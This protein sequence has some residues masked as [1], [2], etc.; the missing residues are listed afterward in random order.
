MKQ[1]TDSGATSPS[2]KGKHITHSERQQIERWLKQ[3][4]SQSEIARLL[5]KSRVTIYREIR[6]GRV[7]QPNSDGT[8]TL[9]YNARHAQDSYAEKFAAHG[10]G[11]K[12]ERNSE[13]AAQL[14]ELLTGEHRYS[15][16]A[17]RQ[18]LID[19]GI[20]V[21]FSS[22]TIYNYIHKQVINVDSKAQPPRKKPRH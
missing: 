17:A 6:R 9:V 4:I 11:L 22:R 5:E 14:V 15:P 20:D 1:D 3:G 7:S 2:R 19:R 12:I 21:P 18:I 8:E 13:L 16:H 10:P